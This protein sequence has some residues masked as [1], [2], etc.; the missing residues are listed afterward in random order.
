MKFSKYW[1]HELAKDK[2]FRDLFT[3]RLPRTPLALF[4][5]KNTC[6][7]TN[8]TVDELKMAL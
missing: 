6:L 3:K 5:N 1:K 7:I 4:K 8:M 2:R